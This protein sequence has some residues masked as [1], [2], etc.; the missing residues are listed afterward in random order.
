MRIDARRGMVVAPQP[1]AA[2]AGALALRRGGNAVDAAIA[3]ALVQGVV[4]PLMCGIA[5][6]GTM[7][8]Y[9]PSRGVHTC[10]DFHGR[11]PGAARPDMWE[12]LVRGEARDG[13]GFILEGRVND[14]GYQSVTVPGALK[15][16]FEAQSEF[17]SFDWSDVVTPAIEHA[18][19]G[20]VVRPGVHA[21]WIAPEEMG[22]ADTVSRLRYSETG[23]RIF[24]NAGGSLLQIGQVVR[25]GDLAET[26]RRIAREGADV[27]YSGDIAAQI[28]ADMRA[29]GG[30][31]TLDDLRSYAATRRDPLWG[32][33][34]GRRI[35]TSNPPGGGAVLLEM[36][37]MLER[38]DLS[39][40]EHNSADYV[41]LVAEVMKWG[42]IDKDQFL[43][44]PQF[45]DVPL[46]MLLS[47]EHTDELIERIRA[48]Q[49][50]DVVRLEQP[51]PRNTT[52]LSVIDADGNAVSMTHSLG[53]PSGVITPGLGFMYNGCM[54]VFDPRPGRAGSIAP[55]KSRFS[56]MC[57][58]IVFDGDR[59]ELVIGAPGGA[60]IAVA[61][62]QVIINILDFQMSVLEGVAAPRFSATS[63]TIDV[64]NR[65]PRY[66][67]DELELRGYPVARSPQSYAFASVHAVHQRADG[68]LD[69]A[70]DPGRDGVALPG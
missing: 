20:F 69:G 28:D 47:K 54:T 65:I 59:P 30:L 35:A 19:A 7:Q 32:E 42:T 4:D 21:F 34:R 14:L 37:N 1:E 25:N 68:T 60:Q 22:R 36:L 15:A 13:F 70:A 3:C 50:A 12:S 29:N 62:L 67:T 10:I 63:N 26:M 45:I 17:G 48:G 5:G 38:F 44:D 58:S 31:L 40:F 9:L 2:E 27:F 55:G 41:A 53:M 8:V 51:E 61:V 64:S 52:H 49:R 33:Y 57:P 16:Y 46:D 23:R 56:A 39:D 11:V 6:F 43:G 18:A 24:F 66:V